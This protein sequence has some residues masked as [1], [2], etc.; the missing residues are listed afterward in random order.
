M[1]SRP[2][3]KKYPVIVDGD[4]SLSSITSSATIIEDLTLIGY[5][6]SWAGTTPIGAVSVEVS[7][8]YAL[9]PDGSIANAGTWTTIT[10]SL[11]GV[12]V[13]SAPVTGN[14][15]TGFIDIDAMSAYAIRTVYTRASGIGTLQCIVNAKVA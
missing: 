11:A 7:N 3:I 4:M 9:G 5:G 15:G 1:S 12:P 6:F 10:F 2:R 13:T 14:T 8:D